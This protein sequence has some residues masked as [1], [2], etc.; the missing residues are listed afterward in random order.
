M[1][2]IVENP[3]FLWIFS[4]KKT[5]DLSPGSVTRPFDGPKN[6]LWKHFHH[7]KDGPWP[8]E[9]SNCWH[10]KS[11]NKKLQT[12][13]VFD[14]SS[15]IWNSSY[16]YEVCLLYPDLLDMWKFCLLVAFFFWVNFGHRF[17]TKERSRYMFS[18][19]TLSNLSSQIPSKSAQKSRMILTFKGQ[20]LGVALTNHVRTWYLLCSLGLLGDWPFF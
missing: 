2:K 13:L 20:L 11:S 19:R 9:T 8:F 14:P 7:G 16:K 15:G 6:H 10:L 5:S 4:K 17:C 12:D 3:S 18:K 1:P